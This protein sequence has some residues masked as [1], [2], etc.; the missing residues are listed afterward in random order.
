M[1]LAVF[2]ILSCASGL[3]KEWKD[4]EFAKPDGVSLTLDAWVPDADLK[5]KSVALLVHGGGWEAGD[6]R[7]YIGPWF[8][9]LTAA[10]IPWVTVN[11]RLG[12]KW[13]HPAAVEDVEAAVRW[14]QG[15]AR[16]LG[17]D[18]KQI[19]LVG[20]SAG[21]HIAALAAMRGRVKVAGWVGFYGIYDVPQWV[22]ERGELPKN[23]AGYLR[24]VGEKGQR[25]ATPV[26]YVKRGQVAILLVHGKADRGVPFAQSER[27][28]E[29]AR[30]KGVDCEMLL[31]E[32]AP[33][34]VDNWEG[35]AEF[36][37]WEEKLV[38]WLKGRRER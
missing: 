1:L 3:A 34:G 16:M 26:E 9:A 37:A 12:P 30:G 32:G 10:G 23:I 13:K 22:K 6:K 19:V 31:I 15:N 36:G 5:G 7:T 27:M 28:C 4:L 2:V 38:G 18:G 29:V 35:K 33:H 8:R 24:D 25:E 17:I 14:V 20:E 21:A 11:Y